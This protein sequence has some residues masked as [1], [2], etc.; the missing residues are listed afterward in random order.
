MGSTES[1]LFVLQGVGVVDGPLVL[2]VR[3]VLLVEGFVYCRIG[4]GAA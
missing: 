1:M 2:F 4:P 3:V